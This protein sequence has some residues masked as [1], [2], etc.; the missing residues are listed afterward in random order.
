MERPTK[1]N[2][3]NHDDFLDARSIQDLEASQFGIDIFLHNSRDLLD[4]RVAKVLQQASSRQALS[5][6]EKIQVLKELS[7]LLFQEKTAR[8]ITIHFR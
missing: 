3:N 7:Y 8:T 1:R 5:L 4:D 2:K 6:D